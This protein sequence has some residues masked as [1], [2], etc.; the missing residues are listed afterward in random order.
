MSSNTPFMDSIE[1]NSQE[2][3][4]TKTKVPS[5]DKSVSAST[6]TEKKGGKQ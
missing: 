6:V 2:K 1:G 4:M 3:T 5:E